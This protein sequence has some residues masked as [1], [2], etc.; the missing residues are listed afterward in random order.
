MRRLVSL[1]FLEIALIGII[2]PIAPHVAAGTAPTLD[3]VSS[4]PI[5]STLASNSISVTLSTSSFPDVIY[6]VFSA[7]PSTAAV[8]TVM[9]TKGLTYSSRCTVS[10]GGTPTTTVLFTYYAIASSTASSDVITATFTA[11]SATAAG[12]LA[13][14]I[15]GAN[16]GVRLRS[17]PG[18][19]R[20]LPRAGPLRPLQHLRAS[21]LLHLAPVIS[22]SEPSAYQA[23]HPQPRWDQALLQLQTMVGLLFLPRPKISR[24][25]LL[26]PAR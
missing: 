10:L 22:S 6:V 1:A 11:L 8:S 13:F 5:S 16:T 25:R 20:A 19:R 15:A 21:P 7:T 9:D 2:L 26:V 4:C 12:M 17:I 24:K 3:C 23:L 14:G 18:S